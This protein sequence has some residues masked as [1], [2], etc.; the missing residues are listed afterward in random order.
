MTKLEVE[1]II[2]K[3]KDFI[4]QII[5]DIKQRH[6]WMPTH[7]AISSNPD[8]LTVGRTVHLIFIEYL[9]VNK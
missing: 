5:T 4:W 1:T 6:N 3:Q 9:M 2:K 8:Y 7:I